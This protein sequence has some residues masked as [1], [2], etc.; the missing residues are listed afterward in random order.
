MSSPLRRSDSPTLR[1]C[2]VQ[3]AFPHRGSL[4][5][6]PTP[7]RLCGPLSTPTA[8]FSAAIHEFIHVLLHINLYSGSTPA[9]AAK[10]TG[11]TT[12]SDVCRPESCE[13]GRL[14]QTGQT[15]PGKDMTSKRGSRSRRGGVRESSLHI[16]L[17]GDEL[18]VL[19]RVSHYYERSMGLMRYVVRIASSR[20]TKTK[21]AFIQDESRWLERFV[22]ATRRHMEEEG[23]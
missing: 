8:G 21:Y 6:S 3:I 19:E 12:D 17:S 5:P 10:P 1:L 13:R 23:A 18:A 9:A 4:H 20:D 22:E 14:A 7:S 15:V 11:V 2:R 16:R